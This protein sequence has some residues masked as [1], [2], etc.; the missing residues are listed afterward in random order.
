MRTVW[1]FGEEVWEDGDG[2][3]KVE[4]PSRLIDK[5]IKTAIQIPRQQKKIS[6]IKYFYCLASVGASIYAAPR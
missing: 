3:D 4:K 6:L 5:C 1:A 2:Q